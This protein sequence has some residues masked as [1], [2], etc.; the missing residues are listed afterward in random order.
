MPRR[1]RV[2]RPPVWVHLLPWRSGSR[3]PSRLM[4]SV[5]VV[6]YGLIALGAATHTSEL[7]KV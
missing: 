5:T 7:L 4:G 3:A 2:L 1:V 6:E